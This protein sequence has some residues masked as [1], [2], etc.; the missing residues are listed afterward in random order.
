MEFLFFLFV[1]NLYH[2]TYSDSGVHEFYW[3][4][5]LQ[6]TDELIKQNNSEA[7]KFLEGETIG[8]CLLANQIEMLNARASLSYAAKQSTSGGSN[9]RS[10]PREGNEQTMG[11]LA[12]SQPVGRT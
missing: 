11:A 12:L 2:E 1:C 10:L 3:T 4:T 9:D 5:F 7:S 8:D 6:S